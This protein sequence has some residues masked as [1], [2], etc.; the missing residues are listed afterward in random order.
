MVQENSEKVKELDK[1]AV[2]LGEKFHSLIEIEPG[3]PEAQLIEKEILNGSK[4]SHRRPQARNR[5]DRRQRARR[6]WDE[7]I[8]DYYTQ[9]KVQNSYFFLLDSQKKT[10]KNFEPQK[11]KSFTPKKYILLFMI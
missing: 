3:D 5:S 4:N 9:D 6:S 8:P 2:I 7:F 10:S 11:R 1:S